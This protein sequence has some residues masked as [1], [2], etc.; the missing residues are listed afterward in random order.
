MGMSVVSTGMI[1][2]K[3]ISVEPSPAAAVAT[4]VTGPEGPGAKDGSGGAVAP[5]RAAASGGP[6]GGNATAKGPELDLTVLNLAV[7]LENL[8]SSFYSQH[9]PP[10]GAF[11]QV[12]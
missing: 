3:A 2:S 8:E 10:S 4:G 7:V 11:P 12:W 9:G 6:G 5:A 1:A